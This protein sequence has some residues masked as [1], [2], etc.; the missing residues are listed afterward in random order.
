MDS[1]DCLGFRLVGAFPLA[2]FTV[3]G[4]LTLADAEAEEGVVRP[5]SPAAVIGAGAESLA[6]D[7]EGPVAT[8][9]PLSAPVEA[10]TGAFAVRKS[11]CSCVAV[12]VP[13]LDVAVPPSLA[14][15]LIFARISAVF[16]SSSGRRTV[17]LSKS[18]QGL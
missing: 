2:L 14:S 13:L 15:Y 3:L 1:S 18:A 10:S 9:T 17:S 5:V 6:P 4:A 16:G 8:F 11:I 12:A 7:E